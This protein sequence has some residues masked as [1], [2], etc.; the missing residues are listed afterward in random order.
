MADILPSVILDD[1]VDRLTLALN[2]NEVTDSPVDVIFGPPDAM[3]TQLI[4]WIRY[5]PVAHE[6]GTLTVT[7]P[8]VSVWVGVPS[9]DYPTD[10]RFITDLAHVISR[11]LPISPG[12]PIG[13]EAFITDV[14]IEE[15]GRIGWAGSEG[16][17]MAAQVIVQMQ[18]KGELRP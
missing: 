9:T 18:F 17:A 5:G 3:P 12:E 16:T 6:W 1:L 15:A 13:G 11:A 4:C 7:L 14:R 10:Y 2:G 8:Q